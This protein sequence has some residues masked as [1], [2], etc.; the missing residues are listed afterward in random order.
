V[1]LP[2]DK[3]Y[4]FEGFIKKEAP[5]GKAFLLEVEGV[6]VWVPKACIDDKS[7]AYE[8]GDEGEIAIPLDMAEEK[9]LV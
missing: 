8:E 1:D 7:E 3:L 6:E 4:F 9:G 5:S 2:R